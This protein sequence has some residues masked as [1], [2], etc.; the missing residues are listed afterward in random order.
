MSGNGNRGKDSVSNDTSRSVAFSRR[1]MLAGSAALAGGL[2]G[3][4]GGGDDTGDGNNSDPETKATAAGDDLKTETEGTTSGE[5]TEQTTAPQ[6]EPIE[7]FFDGYIGRIP[8]K[9]HWQPYHKKT[10]PTV[11]RY[12]YTFLSKPLFTGGVQK[13]MLKDW[14]WSTEKKTATVQLQ[15]GFTWWNGDPYTAEDHITELE[16]GR[17]LDPSGSQFE[18]L[19]ASGENEFKLHYKKLQNPQLVLRSSPLIASATLPAKEYTTWIE[20]LEG[21]SE[22]AKRDEISKKLG[23]WDMPIQEGAIE[24]GYGTGLWQVESATTTELIAKKYEDHPWAD[25]TNIPKMR[26]RLCKADACKQYQ[27][28]DKFDYG[29]GTGFVE[30]NPRAPKNLELLAKFGNLNIPGMHLNLANND[31]LKN[32]GVRRAMAAAINSDEVANIAGGTGLHLQTGLP[33]LLWPSWL[34]GQQEN[35]INYEL[36]GKEELVKKYMTE[37]GYQKN[38]SGKWAKDGETV[39]FEYIAVSWYKKGG[40]TTAQQLKNHGFEVNFTV[41][42]SGFWERRTNGDFDLSF[43]SHFSTYPHPAMY[44]DHSYLFGLHLGSAGDIKRW[45]DEGKTREQDEKWGLPIITEVPKKVGAADLSGETEEINLFE[46]SRQIKQGQSKEEV[47]PAVKKI[48]WWWNFYVPQ[49]SVTQPDEGC[50][51]DTSAFQFPEKGSDT[52]KAYRGMWATWRAG[53]VSA[54]TK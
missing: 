29:L 26:W 23:Q 19:E 53:D 46:L 21:V 35:Y 34:E 50:W 25:K 24:K 4:S 41:P 6:G 18:S 31:H 33:E 44:F 43:N 38:S 11:G 32:R 17:L 15:D 10:P 37:A 51:G 30:D 3:C 16:L 39:S 45:L 40:K 52:Y 7:E 28:N 13:R 47:K 49:I 8:S 20:E 1:K 2:A 9:M 42:S 27:V 5:T 54:K 22:Q 14:S 36:L 48:S 12:F